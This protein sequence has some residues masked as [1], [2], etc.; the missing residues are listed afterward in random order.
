MQPKRAVGEREQAIVALAERQ[1]G[2]VSHSQLLALG[3]AAEAI[4]YRVRANRLHPL[5]R[6]V[7]AVGQR[8]LPR[9]ARWMA[10]VLACGPGTVL[11]HLPAGAHWQLIRDR[12]RREVT[13]PRH[14]RERSG[15]TVHEACLPAD[16]ITVHE[17]IPITTVPRTLFDLATALTPRQLERAINEA[18]VRRLWD[19]LSLEHLLD[20]YPRRRGNPDVRAALQ[21]RSQG[22]TV[23]RSELEDTF[24][25]LTDAAGI[26]RPEINALV[27][28]Y[29]V[30][31]VFRDTRLAV[32][33]D[34]PDTH[35][36]AAA[37][38]ADRERDRV[39]Q[40][41][42]WRVVR[43]TYRQMRDTPSAV[44]RDLRMLLGEG[45]GRLAA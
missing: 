10:A 42:A 2:V 36:T 19:E 39:L 12:G 15:I 38:E 31:A 40:A 17:G 28:G 21:G 1:Y 4:K 22:A 30:D 25:E 35:G 8:Q 41:A 27:E 3:L 33:L 13:V 23:T 45:R 29:E 11:S 7:Y 37:F 43:I 44:I 14:R 26:Q 5:Y 6:G 32:E 9:E 16:E 34:G 18:E 24:L 20:R